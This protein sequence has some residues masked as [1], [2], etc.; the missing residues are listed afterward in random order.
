MSVLQYPEAMNASDLQI[1]N[2][3]AF[4][5]GESEDTTITRRSSFSPLKP[6]FVNRS[7]S[8]DSVSSKENHSPVPRKPLVSV[9]TPLPV[10][11][12]L[13]NGVLG[14]S[15]GIPKK[16]LL[17]N[18]V[19]KDDKK[20]EEVRDETKIDAEIE[21]IQV[22][23]TR[24]SSRLEALRLEKAEQKLKLLEKRGRV[25]SAKFM[26]QKQIVKN[27]DGVK[28]IEEVSSFSSTR[29]VER[30]GFS[31]GPSEIAAGIRRGASLGPSEIVKQLGKQEIVKQLGKQEIIIT[32]GQSITNRRKSCFW[33]LN[34][35]DELKVTKE[36]GKSSS[37]SPKSRKTIPKTQPLRQAVT[38]VG[39]KKAVKKEDGVISAIQPKKLSFKD[40]EKSVPNKKA[41]KPGRV[42]ASRYSQSSGSSVMR[43]RSLP[44]NEESE[45]C[46][47]KRASSIGTPRGSDSVIIQNQGTQSRVKKRW[48]IPSELVVVC[49][50]LVN[51]EEETPVSVAKI[52]EILP[53]IRTLRCPSE[54]PRDSGPAKRVAELI[55][56]KSYFC[57]DEIV[58]EPVCQVLS[59]AEDGEEN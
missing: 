31:L 20:E 45:R 54:T 11:P 27:P 3:A 53:R 30:R 52:P 9:K 18:P 13:S 33:K 42:V 35:I 49:R 22:E 12:L 59:F 16:P 48:E 5:N 47:K 23:I 4:D 8:L 50:N 46:E 43:K 56:R 44:E 41:S 32:P 38:T 58:E 25:I 39:S 34:E 40:G 14:N 7:E 55:G 1:W 6:I 37:I 36:R 57:D 28:K 2:N 51:D 19:L 29:K 17:K 21:E 15:Q 24:L 10:K 26:E